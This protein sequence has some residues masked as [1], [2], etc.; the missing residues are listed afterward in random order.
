M[1]PKSPPQRVLAELK[2][3]EASNDSLGFISVLKTELGQLSEPSDALGI[4]SVIQDHFTAAVDAETPEEA[5]LSDVISIIIP[6]TAVASLWPVSK[7][8]LVAVVDTVRAKEVATMIAD[9]LS[10][11][12]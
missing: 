1:L 9:C 2:A 6:F 10:R 7:S 8:I 4:L 12:G 11:A 3:C 5:V